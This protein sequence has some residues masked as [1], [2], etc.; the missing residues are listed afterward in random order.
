MDPIVKQE[1]QKL[2]DDKHGDE[3]R[4]NFILECINANKK[5]YNSDKKYLAGLLDKHSTEDEILERLG[6]EESKPAIAE[7]SSLEPSKKPKKELHKDQKYC[8][9]CEKTVWPER[10]FSVGALVV[11]LLLGIIPGLIYYAVKNKTCPICKHDQWA[12]PPQTDA[13]SKPA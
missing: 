12:V 9:I 1:I 11:L 4:L 6:F 13:S 7:P 2:I 8:A 5:I 10:N 3:L